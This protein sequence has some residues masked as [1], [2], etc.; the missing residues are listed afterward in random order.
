M[1]T[2][3]LMAMVAL[4]SLG[5]APVVVAQTAV[6]HNTWTSGT[7]M[8][9]AVW[10]AA[11][12][13]LGGK[14]YVVGGINAE[15]GIIADTQIYNPSTDTWSMGVPLPTTVAGAS[16]AVVKNI[17]YVMGG[18]VDGTTYSSAVWAFN[19]KTKTWSSKAAMPT[20]LSDSGAAVENGII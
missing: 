20:A 19:P 1:K 16:G 5:T 18:T 12:G 8:P 6:A 4:L 10:D 14:I 2:K 3:S 7:P 13:P 11:V 17:L 9:T 15:G